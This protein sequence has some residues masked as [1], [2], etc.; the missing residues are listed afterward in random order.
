MMKSILAMVLALGVMGVTTLAQAQ[1]SLMYRNRTQV[2][3][4]VEV[5]KV[6]AKKEEKKEEVAKKDDAKVEK[7]AVKVK[8]TKKHVKKVVKEEVKK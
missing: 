4:V 6:E 2:K 5:K 7:A 1:E 3:K 8:K